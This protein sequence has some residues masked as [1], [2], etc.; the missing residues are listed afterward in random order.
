[1]KTIRITMVIAAITIAW[2][3]TAVQTE[4]NNANCVKVADIKAGN[5][6]NT[7]SE[8]VVRSQ[9]LAEAKETGAD[10]I[11]VK[12]VRKDHGKLGARYYAKAVALKCEN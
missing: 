9:I 6:T 10:T 11:K 7:A 5:K 4:V 8:E 1:M 3:L 12:M 2:S